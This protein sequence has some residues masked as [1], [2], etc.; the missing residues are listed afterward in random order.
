MVVRLEINRSHDGTSGNHVHSGKMIITVI[1][2]IWVIVII[3][4]MLIMI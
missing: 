4:V 3:R 2:E 1:T